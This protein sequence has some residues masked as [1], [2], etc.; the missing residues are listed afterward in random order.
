[1]GAE[2]LLEVVLPVLVALLVFVVPAGAQ[3]LVRW[4]R[5]TLRRRRACSH[6]AGR[7]PI[8]SG[9]GT[10]PLPPP[11]P[12]PKPRKRRAKKPTQAQDDALHGPALAPTPVPG[13]GEPHAG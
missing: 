10:V 13:P 5:A 6:L 12:A 11:A 3:G 7:V 4:L 1:M 9:M 8:D 2:I